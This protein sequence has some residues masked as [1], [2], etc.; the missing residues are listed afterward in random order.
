MGHNI[1]Q[2]SGQKIECDHP[3]YH[4]K[5]KV[6]NSHVDCYPA[7]IFECANEED[8]IEAVQYANEHGLKIT[9]RGGGFHPAGT[10]VK[11]NAVLIDLSKMNR[12]HIDE[13]SNIA[14]VEA[15]AKTFEVDEITQEYGLAVPLGMNSNIGVSG[16]ALGGGI[17]YLRGKYGL[18]SDHI[19]GVYLVTGEAKLIYVNRFEHPELFWAIRGAGANFG[20]VTKFE[21]NLVPVGQHILGIDVIYDYKDYKQIIE[22]AEIYR[23]NA[24]DEI[25]FSIA[26]TKMENDKKCVRLG[27]MYIGDLN[28]QVEKEIIQP[29]LELAT[30]I[31]DYTG[32]MPYIEMQRNFD[33]YVQNGFAIE[34]I[35]LFFNELNDAVINILMEELE[36]S[37]F[38]ASVHLIE[39][40]GEMNRISNYETAFHIRDASYLV[41]V[42]AE[43]GN[44]P[45]KTQAWIQALYEKLLPYSYNQISY[46]NSSNVNEEI[47]RN[48]Y[49]RIEKRLVELKKEYDPK[50]LFCPE[51]NLIG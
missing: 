23:Q 7:T 3:L 24:V 50:N 48:S 47:I 32:I 9:V 44:H 26:I 6:W 12:V 45:E 38:P 34:G 40:H 10:S 1:K 35:S 27:G 29:L 51:H 20:V 13:V 11:D 25:S 33:W 36:G 15:G 42:E 37:H 18:T 16:L 21:F 8:V 31:A 19:V 17:G 43:I 30:P 49:R 5:R 2:K 41:I 22:K 46:L 39:I 28:I 4:L 14:T